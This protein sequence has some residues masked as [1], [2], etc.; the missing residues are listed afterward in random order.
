MSYDTTTRLL[1]QR[2]LELERVRVAR[3]M[4]PPVIWRAR[5]RFCGEALQADDRDTR[6]YRNEVYAH[7]TCVEREQPERRW[8]DPIR[9]LPQ[10]TREMKAAIRRLHAIWKTMQ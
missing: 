1:D 8:P 5:C 6:M 3:L 7:R 2:L 4:N 9:T 10:P